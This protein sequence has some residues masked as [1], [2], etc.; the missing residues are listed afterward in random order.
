MRHCWDRLT[1]TLRVLFFTKLGLISGFLI[2]I[3]ACTYTEDGI[4]VYAPASQ[5]DVTPPTETATTC[6]IPVPYVAGIELISPESTMVKKQWYPVDGVVATAQL[7]GESINEIMAN[8]DNPQINIEYVLVHV[9]GEDFKLFH[10][11]NVTP[12]ANADFWNEV[13]ES[14]AQLTENLNDRSSIRVIW[15]AYKIVE[16]AVTLS[17][18]LASSSQLDEWIVLF[19]DEHNVNSE[20]IARLLFFIESDGEKQYVLYQST[21]ITRIGIPT[22]EPDDE[23][24]ITNREGSLYCYLIDVWNSIT[25]G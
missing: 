2:L 12:I 23:V 22:G 10:S 8:C 5:S 15:P 16:P 25:G 6:T 11:L 17:T 24:C 3:C 4:P 7:T 21:S 13:A 1:S 9:D 14:D 20:N 19:E 18:T